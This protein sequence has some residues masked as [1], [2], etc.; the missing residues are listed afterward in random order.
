MAS[1][2]HGTVDH[3]LCGCSYKRNPPYV[4][5]PV[6]CQGVVLDSVCM[7]AALH[8]IAYISIWHHKIIWFKVGHTGHTVIHAFGRGKNKFTKSQICPTEH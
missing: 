8:S 6:Q 4:S 5:L 3:Y 7:S 2:H 1:G